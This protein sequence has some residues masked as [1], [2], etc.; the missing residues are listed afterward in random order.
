MSEEITN[1]DTA[2][3]NTE[4]AY[5]ENNVYDSTELYTEPTDT[6]EVVDDTQSVDTKE[7]EVD[8]QKPDGENADTTQTNEDQ[9]TN[10]DLER[11]LREYE[12]HKEE[13]ALLRQ[14]LGLNDNVSDEEVSFAN[15]DRTIVNRGQ[16]AYLDLCNRYGVDADLNKL[17]QTIETLK[18]TDPAKGYKF[19]AEVDRLATAVSNQRNEISNYRYASGIQ[20]FE[21]DNAQILSASPVLQQ[22]LSQV[23]QSNAGDPNIYSILNNTMSYIQAIYSEAFNY[24]KQYAVMDNAKRDTS[25]V[26]GSIT[27]GINQTTANAG[28]PLTVAQIRNM[29]Q[30]EFEKNYDAIMRAYAE[31]RIVD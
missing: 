20:Q 23:V 15:M 30:S 18:Q 28:Q 21:R 31:G 8:G 3:L 10:P 6:S 1:T 24:G 9:S 12:L 4:A 14:R 19:E 27:N 11:R 5:I 7:S 29:S 13:Q 17:D 16:T 22:T 26:E 25:K 2:A